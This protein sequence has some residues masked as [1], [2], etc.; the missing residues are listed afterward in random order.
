MLKWKWH[1]AQFCDSAFC[2]GTDPLIYIEPLM[3]C[4]KTSVGS[5]REGSNT[6]WTVWSVSEHV[7]AVNACSTGLLTSQLMDNPGC[8]IVVFL[9]TYWGKFLLSWNLNSLK[10]YYKGFINQQKYWTSAHYTEL[11]LWTKII[12]SL[13]NRNVFFNKKFWTSEKQRKTFHKN[14]KTS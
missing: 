14:L 2:I 11:R 5:C 1:V 4:S 9:Y 8:D 6:S 3:R 13:E 10:V 12:F 7:N